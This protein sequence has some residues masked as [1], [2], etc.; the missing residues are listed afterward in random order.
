MP[1]A[2]QTSKLAATSVTM[3]AI[4]AKGSFRRYGICEW[5]A[6]AL[7]DAFRKKD[8]LLPAWLPTIDGGRESTIPTQF[9]VVSNTNHSGYRLTNGGKRNGF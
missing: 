1:T 6:D 8:G 7:A 4:A 3:I 9:A 5:Y 2:A